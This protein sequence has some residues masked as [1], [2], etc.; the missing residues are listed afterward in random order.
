MNKRYIDFVPV[1]GKA[2]GSVKPKVAV[3]VR[4]RAV[5]SAPK[6]ATSKAATSKAATSKAAT[7]KVATSKVAA[8][9]VTAPAKRPAIKPT[10][11]RRERTSTPKYGVIEDYEPKA[12]F[13]NTDKI[14]KRPL[15]R[16]VAPKKPVV[17]PEKEISDPARIIAKPEKDSKA[18]L[19]IA[20]ILTIILGAA[21]GTVAFLL[22]P[23]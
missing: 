10:S 16:S 9:K 17:V 19:I 14:V 12:R 20:V 13:I 6:V 5:K 18:G 4:P 21:A 1:S 3:P 15:S 8:P 2:D 11:T 7:S 23:K 22:L